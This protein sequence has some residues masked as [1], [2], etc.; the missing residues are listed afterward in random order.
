M[1]VDD[2][3]RRS[4]RLREL[5]DA[6]GEG[7]SIESGA[8]VLARDQDSHQA[9]FGSRHHRLRWEAVVSIDF[10]RTRKCDALG[11]LA[12]RCTKGRVLGVEFEIQLDV[13]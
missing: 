8:T 12:D 13:N 11:E 10:S 2:H 4:A 5:L 7:K 9:G 3:R 1:D 6:D